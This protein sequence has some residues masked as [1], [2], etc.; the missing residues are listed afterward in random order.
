M[1]GRVQGVFFRDTCRREAQ[2]R[3]VTGWVTN[4][5]DDMVEAVFEGPPEAVDAMVAWARVGPRAADVDRLD[6][7]DVDSAGLAEFQVR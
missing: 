5:Y 1:H 3:G 2:A 4:R 6:V 7:T